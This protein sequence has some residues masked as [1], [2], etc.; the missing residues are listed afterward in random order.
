MCIF[1]P[2]NTQTVAKGHIT[3]RPKDVSLLNFLRSE[4][5]KAT[6]SVNQQMEHFIKTIRDSHYNKKIDEENNHN[7]ED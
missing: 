6:R 3:F 1:A 2:I 7:K 4:A 5:Q